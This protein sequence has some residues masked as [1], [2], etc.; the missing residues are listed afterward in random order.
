MFKLEK[1]RKLLKQ[2]SEPVWLNTANGLT[3]AVW[4]T[5]VYV[6]DLGSEMEFLCL[7]ET[8]SVVSLG[9]L[10]NNHGYTYL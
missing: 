3:A 2:L 6:Q 1:E 4:I 5:K 10:C 7:D 8:P 9:C